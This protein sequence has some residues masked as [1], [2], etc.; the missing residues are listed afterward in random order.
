MIT[1]QTLRKELLAARR[2]LRPAARERA[3]HAVAAHIANS[4][5][6][7]PGKRIGLYASMA[8][9]L[10]TAPLIELARER[11]CEIFLPR[12]TSMRARR[13][14]FVPLNP[15]ARRH[16]FGM[17]EPEGHEWLG[18]RFLDTIFVAGVGFDRH[19][20]RLGHGAGFYDRALAFRH[21]RNHWRGPRLVGLAY[22]FQVV[23]HIPVTANDVFMDYIVTDRGI[24]ELLA[25]EDG[26][27][28]LRSR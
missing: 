9:E 6:L 21:L 26:A 3:A 8:Q 14:R 18:A 2:A 19:G 4:R 7:A 11:G 24:D 27:V 1:K 23:P 28:D 15:R 22:S 5:W 12:I 20:A 25:D 17:I 13:M 10:G 16:S